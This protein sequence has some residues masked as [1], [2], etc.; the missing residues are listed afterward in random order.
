MGTK[1]Y[2]ASHSPTKFSLSKANIS[3]VFLHSGHW[4]RP[5]WQYHLQGHGH[6]FFPSW[7][8]FQ[9]CQCQRQPFLVGT[10]RFAT[11]HLISD[12]VKFWRSSQDMGHKESPEEIW[13][14][15]S[16]KMSGGTHKKE[17][18]G[19]SA[20]NLFPIGTLAHAKIVAVWLSQQITFECVD[21]FALKTHWIIEHL[22]LH[23]CWNLDTFCIEP[24]VA[25]I[26]IW[27][28]RSHHRPS[29]LTNHD[30]CGP[31]LPLSKHQSLENSSVSEMQKYI[32]SLSFSTSTN[33]A[34]FFFSSGLA[35]HTFFTRF[36]HHAS[37]S[38][39][40]FLGCKSLVIN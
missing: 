24:E 25:I 27:I 17:T 39:L 5:T 40:S 14:D 10:S 32:S 15:V 6:F 11:S 16:K 30:K 38:S 19:A 21:L 23:N 4:T 12:S 1:L 9:N 29:T 37:S 35:L 31:I 34:G 13:P 22:Y 2:S 18:T 20:Q 36:T 3:R 8:D 26:F 7:S 28:D 33:C